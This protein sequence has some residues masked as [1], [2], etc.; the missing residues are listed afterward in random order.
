M[1]SIVSGSG[2]YEMRQLLKHAARRQDGA[3]IGA[4]I[5]SRV[6]NVE[7]GTVACLGRPIWHPDVVSLGHFDVYKRLQHCEIKSVYCRDQG[8]FFSFLRLSAIRSISHLAPPILHL[9]W[10]Y[11]LEAFS[12]PS[13]LP[14]KLGSPITESCRAISRLDHH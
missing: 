2:I 12:T 4:E 13:I 8:P 10:H 9:I 3:E 14:G 1:D 7:M 6:G 11:K 5:A